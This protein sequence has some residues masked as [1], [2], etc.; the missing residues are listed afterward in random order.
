MDRD[1]ESNVNCPMG[2]RTW[3]KISFP[4][5]FFLKFCGVYHTHLPA[6]DLSKMFGPTCNYRSISFFFSQM[7]RFYH[8]IMVII[9]WFKLGLML[10]T[11]WILFAT[12]N[13]VVSDGIL[14]WISGSAQSAINITILFWNCERQAKF[15]KFITTFISYTICP[16]KNY[17]RTFRMD[18]FQSRE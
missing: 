10:Q 13:L 6:N 12:H 9:V 5:M 11:L 3:L 18:N 2:R 8:A 4:I 14:A 15:R 17:N 1:I 16:K 7:T